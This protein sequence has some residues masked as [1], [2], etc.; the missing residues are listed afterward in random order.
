VP[1]LPALPSTRLLIAALCLAGLP[2]AAAAPAAADALADCQWTRN[3][4][5]A[6]VK[7][8]T[9][10]IEER[11]APEA[12]MHFNRGLALKVLGR[13]EEAEQDYTR[14]IE[15][16][17]RYA[18]AYTNRGNVRALRNDLAGALADYRKAL[19]LDRT[20]RV[21]RQNLKA[22]EKALRRIGADKSGKGVTSGP[23]R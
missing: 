18:A 21:A 13:L 12:W 15:R 19:S 9:L 20:D 2:L 5:E 7:G 4:P 3:D 8:C 1:V 14:A 23:T 17:P 10:L 6:V 16:N 22:I 11:A